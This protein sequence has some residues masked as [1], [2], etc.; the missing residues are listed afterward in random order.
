MSRIDQKWLLHRNADPLRHSH[1]FAY[2]LVYRSSD[3]RLEV[4][5]CAVIVHIP[6]M[7]ELELNCLIVSHG[8]EVCTLGFAPR[9]ETN[10]LPDSSLL[11]QL[12]ICRPESIIGG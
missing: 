12:Y 9:K 5:Y 4:D 6:S 7:I 8:Q 11:L 2:R 1:L 10:S 3:T